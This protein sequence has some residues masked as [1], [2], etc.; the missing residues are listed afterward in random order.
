MLKKIRNKL[1]SRAKSGRAGSE[2]VEFLFVI[3][4]LVEFTLAMLDA[5]I[6]FNDRNIII[7][8]AQ[9]GARLTAVYGGSSDTAIS[10]AYGQG[11]TPSI[12]STVHA[13]GPAA[14][15]VVQSLNDTKQAGT[16]M[17]ITNVH[18]DV[19]SANANQDNQTK[20]TVDSLQDRPSCTIEYTYNGLPGSIFSF[21]S[22]AKGTSQSITETSNAE[23]IT[24]SN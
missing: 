1:K 18:C 19:Q 22:G 15:E 21:V 9:Q 6:Y 13:N 20:A 16:N 8:A 23:V 3:L 10:R 24:N 7:N 5:G 2:T 14:C 12:C 17:D 11:S 4:V